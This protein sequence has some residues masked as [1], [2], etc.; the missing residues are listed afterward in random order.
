MTHGW[1]SFSYC[2]QWA[3]RVLLSEKYWMNSWKRTKFFL[4]G[5]KSWGLKACTI[6]CRS[7]AVVLECFINLSLYAES[8]RCS[9]SRTKTNLKKVVSR[10]DLSSSVY[11]SKWFRTSHLVLPESPRG[12]ANT[13]LLFLLLVLHNKLFLVHRRQQGNKNLQAF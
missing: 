3:F 10:F 7:S 8:K 4:S 13:S 9:S 6:S 1:Q 11:K 5:S 2:C 12:R